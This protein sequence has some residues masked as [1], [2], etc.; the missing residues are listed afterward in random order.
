MKEYVNGVK[1]KKFFI[2]KSF[3]QAGFLFRSTGSQHIPKAHNIVLQTTAPPKPA[4]K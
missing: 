2:T 1:S 3:D 4:Q